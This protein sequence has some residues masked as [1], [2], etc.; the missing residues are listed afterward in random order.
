MTGKEAAMLA[1]QILGRYPSARVDDA[2]LAVWRDELA[3]RFR[4][5]PYRD[6]LDLSKDFCR[7]TQSRWA[8]S[9]DELAGYVRGRLSARDTPRLEM[10]E[11]SE[12]ERQL[13]KRR[14]QEIRETLVR[15]MG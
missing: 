9:V 8:P 15:G 14:I 12:A 2:V 4:E 7:R 11:P 6:V 3:E 1:A 5:I 13:A 10:P